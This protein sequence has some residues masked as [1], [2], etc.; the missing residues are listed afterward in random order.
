[1]G[2]IQDT[3]DTIVA[4]ST[5]PG[6]GGIGIVRISGENAATVA[7]KFFQ[8][9]NKKVAVNNF[10]THKAIYGKIIDNSGNIIDEALC[11]AMWAPNSY[12]REN[13]IEIQSHGGSL[14]IRRILEL[15][16]AN[17][18]RLAEPGEFTKRAFL[19]GRIDL[20]QAQ[21]VMD[22]IKAHS[23]ASLRMAAGQLQG[24]L[25]KE[26]KNM[27]HDILE[28]IAHLEA[29]I[30]FPEDDIE[31]IAK[32]NAFKKVTKIKNKIEKML[33]TFN[34][35]RILRDGLVTAIVGKPNVGKSSLLNALLRE[36]RAIVTDIPGTTRDSLEEY[37]NIGGVPLKIVD[38]A[39][40][41]ETDDKVEQ[42]GVEKSVA[43]MQKADLI[44]ALF[45]TS[46]ELSVEDE[47]IIEL[48]KE[49][50]GL[51]LLTKND[52]SVK[53]DVEDLQNRLVG[54]FK[55]IYISTVKKNGLKELEEEIV[56]RVYA[57]TLQEKESSFI[58]SVR[59]KDALIE[60]DKYLKDCL[61]TI[62]MNMA[63]D[64]IVIDIRSAWEKLGEITGD[65]VDEDII[66]QIFSQFCIGK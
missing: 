47:E 19:N 46:S 4:V 25:A 29:S 36:E 6:E 10:E 3:N 56:N 26:I 50:E 64:F 7:N 57:G 2:V 62:K 8:P 51:I 55:Y 17:G 49:K 41:R 42:I 35:G 45:D 48:L 13:V 60:A 16:L 65:T 31:D 40:I 20:S 12:T 53:M 34:T 11:I 5:P 61:N 37:A 1:M 27:R 28:I 22:V 59:Q 21:S 38:T 30:D 15:S 43:Y 63:E 14:V 32:E 54:N 24:E 18:A 33:N 58:S 23:D 44:L 52:L 9:F 66:D 39:G